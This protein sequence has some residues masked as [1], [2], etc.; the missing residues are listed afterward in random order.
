MPSKISIS[1]GLTVAQLQAMVAVWAANGGAE[2]RIYGGAMPASADSAVGGAVKLVVINTS[3]NEALG[4]VVDG[5]LLQKVP[6]EVWTGDGIAAGT[7]TFFRLC[8]ADDSD[9]QSLT[10][11]RIQGTCDRI[12]ADL[13]LMSTDVVIGQP[14]PVKEF[15]YS[16]QEAVGG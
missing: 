14:V 2:I 6:L 9:A 4:F 16:F 13:N 10:L 7:A 15:I 8:A 5:T 3:A 12:D 1:T 11:P